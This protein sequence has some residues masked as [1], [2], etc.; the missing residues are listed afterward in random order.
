M[1]PSLINRER[2]CFVDIAKG[3]AIILVVVEHNVLIFKHNVAAD[4]IILSFHMPLFYFASG[5]FFSNHQ[6]FNTILGK[7]FHS[8]VKP[9]LVSCLLFFVLKSIKDFKIGDI[10]TFITGVLYGTNTS[11][12]W[13]Y[14]QLW[15]LTS[16]FVTVLSC[17]GLYF[18][19]NRIASDWLRLLILFVLLIIGVNFIKQ[20]RS[21]QCL[22]LPWNF[23][24]LGVTVFFYAFGFEMRNKFFRGTSAPLI[25][26]TSA[27]LIFL[28][29]HYFFTIELPNDPCSI[30]LTLRK[31]DHMLV[32]SL[33][34]IFG[35]FFVIY[36]SMAIEKYCST[37][38]LF[39]DF[40]GRRSLAIFIFHVLVMPYIQDA[41]QILVHRDDRS[42]LV[43]AFTIV[44]TIGVT[45]IIHELVVR[46]PLAGF[47]LLNE[48]VRQKTGHG[49]YSFK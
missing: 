12:S 10:T 38:S 7:R 47:L 18:F 13:P 30:H 40:I 15:F 49:N 45:I 22:G 31:Y 33:E 9:Y 25:L 17:R 34:A 26:S 3:F 27:L 21:L 6:K 28:C 5:I 4:V 16:L 35:I 14:E 2:K 36:L 39:L 29:L 42:S 32:N 41:I 46:F 24:L 19:L 1:S 20:I 43:F 23:D 11:L 48:R 44:L 37:V 8:L